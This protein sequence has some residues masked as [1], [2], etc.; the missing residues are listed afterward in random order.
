MYQEV[1][2]FWFEELEP[3][4]WWQKDLVFDQMIL[5]RFGK[6]HYQA[7]MGELFTWRK[8]AL[9]CL[10]EVLILDQF[11]RNIYR[12][13]P[14]SFAC[15]PMALALSQSAIQQ[16]FDK[17]LSN[18]QRSFLYMPFMH[19]ESKLIHAEAVK[20]YK[21]VG[22]ENNLNFELQHKNIIDEFGR[23]PHRNQILGRVSTEEELLFLQ[24][25]NSSF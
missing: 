22:L 14:E 6:L 23:Y 24:Q 25:P 3:Q 20:L 4:Q 5:E 7:Q 1:I 12:D 21:A 2:K 15:D 17:P 18:I 8:T 19:S 10:A 9:G 11:S 16:G 13:K